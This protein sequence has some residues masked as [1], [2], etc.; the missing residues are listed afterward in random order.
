MII[1]ERLEKLIKQ[2]ATIWADSY[3]EIQLCNKSEEYT[4]WAK[5]KYK[6]T[7]IKGEKY[8]GKNGNPKFATKSSC[9]L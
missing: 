5:K 7:V 3:G 2:E 6:Q 1:R 8:Y 9:D 4:F